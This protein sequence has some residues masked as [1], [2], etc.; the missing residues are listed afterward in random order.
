MG[1]RTR[2][3]FIKRPLGLIL[4]ML[5]FLVIGAIASQS[6]GVKF[7]LIVFGLMGFVISCFVGGIRLIYSR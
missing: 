3:D 2:G 5:P 7:V 4:L 1:N 6:Y